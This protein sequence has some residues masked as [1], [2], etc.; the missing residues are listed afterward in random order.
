MLYQYHSTTKATCREDRGGRQGTRD[1]AGEEIVEGEAIAIT[2]LYLRRVELWAAVRMYDVFCIYE[3]VVD[4][5][6]LD[7][8]VL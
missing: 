2:C 8:L 3:G 5:D 4:G 1:R 7:I 6:V